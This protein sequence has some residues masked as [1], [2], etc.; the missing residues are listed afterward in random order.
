MLQMLHARLFGVRKKSRH[1]GLLLIPVMASLALVAMPGV[2]AAD[3]AD[4]RFIEEI[5][6]TARNVGEESL[7]DTLAS[8]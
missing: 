8:P 5:L 1:R 6:V 2:Y 3:T 7:Q 4:D